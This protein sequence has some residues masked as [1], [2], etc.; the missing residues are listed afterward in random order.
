MKNFKNIINWK[1]FF[2]LV[3]AC[4]IGSALVL[5]YSLELTQA[6]L[7]TEDSEIPAW[8]L[9]ILMVIQYLVMFAVVTF[10]GL[11]ISKKIGLENGGLRLP[12]LEGIL[13]KE[14]KSKEFK[15]LLVPSI[16]LGILAGGLII[17]LS[18]P[19]NNAIPEFKNMEAVAPVFWKGFL[20]SFYGGIAEEVLLRL[21][22]MSLFVWIS[23]KIKKSKDGS[24]T[25]V[26]VWIAIIL[27]AIIFGVGHLPA[28]AAIA[29]LTEVLIARTLVLNGIGGIIFGWL[30][31]KKGLESAMIAHFSADIVLHVI[32]PLVI[33][34]VS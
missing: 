30:Y 8:L 19:F 9:I 34:I 14:K 16:C 18:I 11:L 29:E 2:I 20:A 5:P 28:A 13:N 3:A 33:S 10:F 27:A 23:F 24:P 31:W 6:E 4:I 22:F 15:A 26:G 32:T 7:F 17:V 25:A 21:F 1:L 12:I